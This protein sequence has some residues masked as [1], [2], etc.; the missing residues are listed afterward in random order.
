MFVVTKGDS[1]G[2]VALLCPPDPLAPAIPINDNEL[3]EKG[4][5][6]RLAR[7]QLNALDEANETAVQLALASN[8][9]ETRFSKP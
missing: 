6:L 3:L 7:K 1:E 9:V 4:F 8:R 2:L 5:S